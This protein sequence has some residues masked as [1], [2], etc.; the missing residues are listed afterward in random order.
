MHTATQLNQSQFSIRLAGEHT[1]CE[2]LLP[3]WAAEDRFGIVVHEAFGALGASLLIQAVI[4]AFFDFAPTRRTS[5]AQYPEIYVFHVGGRYGDF[6]PFDFWPSRKEVF[7]DDDP[8]AVLGSINDRAITR[9]AVPDSDPVPVDFASLVS[10]GWS[11]CNSARERI[12]GAYAYSPRGRV[13][14][15]DVSISGTDPVTEVN[16][17]MVLDP[18]S[19]LDSFG[20]LT[21]EEYKTYGETAEFDIRGWL[22]TVAERLTE[23]PA[24]VRRSVARQRQSLVEDGVATE[25]YRRISTDDALGMLVQVRS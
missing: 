16:G 1:Q 18:Q 22:K 3:G 12:K 21:S 2:G 17:S 11:E 14:N 5:M 6:S 9:I 4:S 19:T 10:A 13:G 25:T 7:I 8:V 24:D 20:G 23:Q 15:P